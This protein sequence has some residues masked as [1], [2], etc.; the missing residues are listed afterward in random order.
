MSLIVVV[1]RKMSFILLNCVLLKFI[2][3]RS[4]RR[5]LLC[6]AHL[7]VSFKHKSALQCANQV[8]DSYSPRELG[9]ASLDFQREI[10][11][12]CLDKTLTIIV[13]LLYMYTTHKMIHYT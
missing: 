5:Y 8:S 11:N 1:Q 2:R 12:E 6:K 3:V 9:R 10:P 4:I 7:L 13:L